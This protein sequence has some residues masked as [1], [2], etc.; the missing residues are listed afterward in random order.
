MTG[1]LLD[2]HVLLWLLATPERLG[3]RCRAD[4]EAATQVRFSAASIWELRIKAGLGKVRVP[5][6]LAV[7]AV[8]AGLRELPV[9]S[10]HVDASVGFSLPHRDPFDRLLVGQ[11]SQERL[12]LLTADRALLGAGLP[13]VRDAAR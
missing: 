6:G 10:A 5:D 13:F 11:A 8:A 9:T 7:A 12:T 3:T 2:S 1:Y 4:L